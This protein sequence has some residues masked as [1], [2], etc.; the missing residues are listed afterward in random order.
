VL[1][2]NGTQLERGESVKI[3]NIEAAW[4][5]VQQALSGTLD[6]EHAELELSGWPIIEVVIKRDE[7]S[8]SAPTAVLVALAELQANLN[9]TVAQLL[10]NKDARSLS[11]EELDAL[12][13]VFEFRDGSSDIKADFSSALTEFA[14]GAV[15]K[16][17]GKH[18]VIVVLGLAAIVA[19]SHTRIREAEIAAQVSETQSHTTELLAVARQNA[20]LRNLEAKQ[21]ASYANL[22]KNARGADAVNLNGTEFS[23]DEIAEMKKQSR[24]RSREARIDNDYR[25]T[26][27]KIYYDRYRL[28]LTSTTPQRTF[29]T[30][31]FKGHPS[32]NEVGHIMLAAVREEPVYLNVFARLAENQVVSATILG[33]NSLANG[34]EID[35]SDEAEDDDPPVG[36]VA[37]E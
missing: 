29:T 21:A 9:R 24:T 31:L 12:E 3:E 13:L 10:Y 32:S 18:I 22:L 15:G 26:Y 34:A 14:K 7:Y 23:S 20:A 19:T 33:L 2:L 8:S 35:A 5:A 4:E 17:D 16:M 1:P 27:F 28:E 11:R 36:G 6:N 25:I 30:D 37:L